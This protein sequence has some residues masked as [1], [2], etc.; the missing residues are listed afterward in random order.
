M[1]INENVL[2][3]N[4]ANFR[5]LC[6]NF[7]SNFW[8]FLVRKLAI[9]IQKRISIVPILLLGGYCSIG[10]LIYYFREGFIIKGN[11]YLFN[12][13][14]VYLTVFGV[15]L[16]L[17]IW[18]SLH[19][20]SLTRRT[21][22]I[23]KKLSNAKDL[24]SVQKIFKNKHSV[25]SQIWEQYQGTFFLV[26][27]KKS[28][29]KEISVL[30]AMTR[31]DADLY[32][33]SDEIIDKAGL[34]LP[35]TVFIK[36][37]PGSFI[38]L[39]ILGT[40][41]GFSQS[42]NFDTNAVDVSQLKTLFSG[43][44][45]AFGTSIVGVL[46]SLIFNFLIAHP[47]ISRMNQNC[48]E[49]S[50]LLDA[51]FFATDADLAHAALQKMDD[52]IK[53]GR[54]EFAEKIKITTDTLSSV[55][56][57]LKETPSL[58]EESNKELQNTINLISDTT[59]E[60]IN[61]IVNEIKTSLSAELSKV[62]ESFDD[63]AK[64]IHD[65]ASDISGIPN[66]ISNI[67]EKL[68]KVI[69]ETQESYDALNEKWAE[70]ISTEVHTI[71]TDSSSQVEGF[72]NMFKSD[73]SEKTEYVFDNIDNRFNDSIQKIKTDFSDSLKE[74]SNKSEEMIKDSVNNVSEKF[75][76]SLME[77]SNN[78]KE[79]LIAEQKVFDEVAE[80]FKSTMNKIIEQVDFIPSEMN[81]LYIELEKIPEEVKLI[82]EKF[83]T[84]GLNETIDRL[85]ALSHSLK[86]EEATLVS[87]MNNSGDSFKEVVLQIVETSKEFEK[88][89]ESMKTA[90]KKF[91][92]SN[93]AMKLYIDNLLHHDKDVT[94]ILTKILEK[95]NSSDEEEK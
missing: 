62:T 28:D 52:I 34:R 4:R 88:I 19:Y 40:F 91:E 78:H 11:E 75:T 27:N 26:D 32:F 18:A 47:L 87:L 38:G 84:L 22:R 24:K 25:F 37:I 57:V 79:Q 5:K 73:I 54:D 36:L 43:L 12:K 53:Q 81:K 68:E 69:E 90:E 70:A 46:T 8:W 7:L 95:F 59:K 83:D 61:F 50:D 14:P 85:Q 2:L 66:E 80:N 33:N 21:F 20:Y 49:L 89:N 63:S 77:L 29:N 17:S 76:E 45:I 48:R 56:D 93:T 15:F 67:K 92:S 30:D 3:F 41:I 6:Y 35:F 74:I 86:G 51:Y 71:I 60:Q 9:K 82:N 65:A 1:G 16:F 58:I 64:A 31:A 42:V 72:V 44:S 39:G 10:Y 94:E 23:T 55:T 13:N